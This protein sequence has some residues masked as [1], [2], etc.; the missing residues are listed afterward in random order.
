MANIA[1]LLEAFPLRN[2]LGTHAW[3]G[4]QFGRMAIEAG[5]GFAVPD[6]RVI[7]NEPT[8]TYLVGVVPAARPL[9]IQP[10]TEAQAG[11][12]A[13]ITDWHSEGINTWAAIQAG[14]LA[15][16]ALY[17]ALLRSIQEVYAFDVLAYWGT[18][19]TV[20]TV[21]ARLGVQML[22]AEYGPLRTP[23]QKHF[24]LDRHGV[25]GQASSR[26]AVTELILIQAIQNWIFVALVLRYRN[27]FVFFGY[28]HDARER[29]VVL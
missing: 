28:L 25:N 6:L 24:C 15:H 3:I 21:A 18:N 7:C 12:K 2:S 9:L 11:F 20:R 27:R 10:S 14:S 26:H 23:F 22:W 16:E 5:Q 19:E 1:V 17:E 4:N 8:M 13:L 29:L